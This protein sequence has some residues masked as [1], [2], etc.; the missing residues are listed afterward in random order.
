MHLTVTMLDLRKKNFNFINS[1]KANNRDAGAVGA[2]APVVV[3]QP[4]IAD[5]D[6]VSVRNFIRHY[7]SHKHNCYGRCSV[8]LVHPRQLRN[9]D[10]FDYLYG[11][12][13]IDAAELGLKIDSTDN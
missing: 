12:V 9:E 4:E 1:C 3:C 13:E 6:H 8:L 10:E 11:L 2:M 5:S 7:T